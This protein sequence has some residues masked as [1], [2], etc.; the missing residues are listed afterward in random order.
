MACFAHAD[1]CL[2]A[3]ASLR[4]LLAE[5]SMS[6]SRMLAIRWTFGD[7]YLAGGY[8]GHAN[9]RWTC[10]APCT[11]RNYLIQVL[12]PAPPMQLAMR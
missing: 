9:V 11:S 2:S 3:A 4:I 7:V 1:W 10:N 5:P 8:Q 12:L 6:P